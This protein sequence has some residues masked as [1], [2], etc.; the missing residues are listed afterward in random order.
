MFG[1]FKKNKPVKIRGYSGDRKYGIASKDVKELIKKGCKLLQLPLSG[2][3][4]CLY[5]DGTIVTEEFFP[6]LPDNCEL[7]LLSRGQ[8]WSGVV[9]DI[10]RLLNTD[11]HA[12]GLIEAAKGLLA[13][14]KSFKR[15]KVLTDLLQ[16]L[17]DRSDLET[18]EE[19]EDWF[20]G[21]DVRFKTKSAY[22][23]YNCES[24]IRGYVK[25]V[26]NATNSIQ[27]AKVKE[28]FLKASKCL[29]EMLKNDKYNGKY[30]DRTEKESGRLCTK[31]G[32]F[33]CQGSF[34]QKLCQLL[35]SINPYGSRESRI[36]FST[37]NLDHRIE[38]KR[39]IIPALLEALQTHKTA[40]INLNYFYQ[41]LFTREN[42][43]LVH[44]VCHKKGAHDLTCDTNKMFRT[45][46]NARKAKE[47]TKG[48]KKHCT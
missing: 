41:M 46:K 20:T 26:D 17:E 3:H 38:K 2:A 33:T 4:V 36:V 24:R 47:D 25:E 12:D 45:S 8:T 9:C 39:T 15:R 40:D 44:I 22:M 27:K 42:L 7:V 10:G 13:D 18:R 6:T 31:E 19:D 23:K 43:K 21:V 28:E 5:E 11:R 14:E 34:E 32:W 29:V 35:H 1:L 30:F 48:K 16:N 37:W